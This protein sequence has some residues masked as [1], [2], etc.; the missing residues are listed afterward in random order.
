MKQNIENEGR[1]RGTE[2]MDGGEIRKDNGKWE[3]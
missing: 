2:K 1:D 3:K